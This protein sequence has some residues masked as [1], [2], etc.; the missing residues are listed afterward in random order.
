MTKAAGGDWP[1]MPMVKEPEEYV[2]RSGIKYRCACGNRTHLGHFNQCRVAKADE[3]IQL[4]LISHLQRLV[5]QLQGDKDTPGAVQNPDPK[6]QT[7]LAAMGYE[8]SPPWHCDLL[9]EMADAINGASDEELE[10]FLAQQECRYFPGR[11]THE[12]AHAQLHLAG[13]SPDADWPYCLEWTP[14]DSVEVA[15]HVPL[16][17]VPPMVQVMAVIKEAYGDEFDLLAPIYPLARDVLDA[18]SKRKL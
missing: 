9:I 3:K 11:V 16:G 12:E 15:V 2:V 13:A 8:L 17:W 14:D 1:S 18:S 7:Q 10:T 5:K 6:Y 4:A